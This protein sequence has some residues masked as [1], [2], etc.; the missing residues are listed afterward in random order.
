MTPSPERQHFDWLRQGRLRL[1]VC[2]SCDRAIFYPRSLCPL[3]GQPGLEWRDAT[4]RGTV[5]STTVVRRPA[6]AGG[7]YNVALIDLDEGVRMMSRVDGVDPD[8]VAIGDRV[9]ARILPAEGEGDPLAV[10]VPA[11]VLDGP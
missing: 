9:Q 10:F 6:K 3:C 11:E 1:Q 2:T 4:G 5:H 8:R 7:D